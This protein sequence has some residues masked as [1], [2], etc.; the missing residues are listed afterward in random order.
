MSKETLD[1]SGEG[2]A[3][4]AEIE[5]IADSILD[6]LKEFSSPKDAGSAFT[7]A[8]Y[9]MIT[10]AFPPKFKTEAIAALK[11]HSQ[12]VEEFLNEGWK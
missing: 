5:F 1:L 11:G 8:H 10:A 2:K 7:L 6:I 12:L 4:D 9:K 3:S